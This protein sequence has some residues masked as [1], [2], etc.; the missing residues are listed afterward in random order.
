M[1]FLL[2]VFFGVLC[3]S[4]FAQDINM[5]NGKFTQCSGVLF[6]SG[7]NSDYSNNE[8]Y[9]ITICPQ[10][11]GQF[12]KLDFTTF[13]TQIT[14]KLYIYDGP[15]VTATLIKSY[16]GSLSP[17]VIQATN[18]SGCL[19]LKFVSS[20]GTPQSGWKANISCDEPCQTIISQI[21]TAVP[22]PNTDG[23]IQVCVNDEIK[24][25]GSGEFGVSGAGAT[26][27][28]D[29]G[30]GRTQ[31]G[32]SAT[33]SYATPGFYFVKLNISDSNTSIDPTGCK[34]TNLSKQVIQV[35]SSVD[36]TGTVATETIF[37]LGE[38]TTIEGV[39]KEVTFTTDCTTLPDSEETF[40]P[41]GTGTAYNTSILIDCFESDQTLDDI[42]QLTDICL[43]MEHSWLNDLDIDIISPTGEKVR[44]H[45][46]EDGKPTWQSANLGTPWATN[47][48]DRQSSNRTPGIG[49][50]YCF[51]PSVPGDSYVTLVDGIKDGG[52]FVSGHGP[53]NNIYK[54]FFVPAGSYSSVESLD[55][56]IGSTLN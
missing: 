28:W 23:Y 18:A 48:D 12:T 54:D 11:A 41:D 52:T 20:F 30:D 15:S 24:L 9:T 31:S 22:S 27:E 33:F 8:N 10:T 36:F 16:N 4:T 56:L 6:D 53:S 42:S 43:E 40:L 17:R 38:S 21:D 34:N 45:K 26:Y 29:L 50:Q 35:S 25:T 1:K 55:G 39:A 37:C 44:L 47:E 51:V 3:F 32:Q 14:D 49:S 7:G 46:Q 2:S 13:N 5:Q 19:T